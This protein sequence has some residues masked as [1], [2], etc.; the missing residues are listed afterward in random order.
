M[1]SQQEC[2]EVFGALGF[3]CLQ[4]AMLSGLRL[5]G[6]VGSKRRNKRIVNQNSETS[7]SH[8]S[9]IERAE[10]KLKCQGDKI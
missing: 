2:S 8:L 1:K 4:Q 9:L 7:F 5:S 3:T 10:I 6:I